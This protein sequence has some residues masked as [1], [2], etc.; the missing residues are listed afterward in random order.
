VR[1]A[2]RCWDDTE[3]QGFHLLIG[4]VAETG[5]E[6]EDNV[7][8]DRHL[9]QENEGFPNAL[10]RGDVL[11]KEQA[12][13][14]PRRSARTTCEETLSGRLEGIVAARIQNADASSPPNTDS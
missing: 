2:R 14:A 7:G 11:P 13:K 3:C 9:E 5:H 12:S 4:K 1:A 6:G 8:Q 10:Q